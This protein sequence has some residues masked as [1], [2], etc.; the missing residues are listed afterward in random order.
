MIDCGGRVKLRALERGDLEAVA[1][2]LEQQP[3]GVFVGNHEFPVPRGKLERWYE[4]ALAGEQE[5][6]M[7]IEH[8]GALAGYLTFRV[9]WR[10]REAQLGAVLVAEA[11]RGRGVAQAAL[12]GLLGALFGRWELNRV[13]LAV[14]AAN[15]TAA[16]LYRKLGMKEEGRLRRKFHL[17][18][19]WHDLLILAR[20]AD[21]P[22]P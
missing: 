16:N 20:L 7:A 11:Y 5:H 13:S 3:D 10:H 22:P 14:H 2:W 17:D 4:A 18:G 19:H 15:Q 9:D 21:D 12:G 6:P 1:G 8:Q